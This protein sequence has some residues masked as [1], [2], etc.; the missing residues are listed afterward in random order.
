MKYL[1]KFLSG[2]YLYGTN[3]E[4]SDKDTRGVFIADKLHYLGFLNNI[5]QIEEKKTDTVYY[6]LKKFFNLCSN[7]NPNIVEFLFVPEDKLELNSK[8]WQKI[9]ENRHLFLSTKARWTFSGYAFSQLNRIKSHREWL[10]NPPK[11]KPERK[12]FGL[13]TDRKV[14]SKEQIG[15]FNQILINY[16]NK[17]KQYHNLKDELELLNEDKGMDV[18]VQQYK[19]MPSEKLVKI[20]PDFSIDFIELVQKEKKFN[21]SL[22]QYNQYLNWKKTR[23]PVRAKL[24]EKYG[25]DTKHGLHLV[26]LINEGE[27]LLLNGHIT[28]PRPD[29]EFLLSIKNGN[30]TYD[31]L[32]EYI[33]DLEQKFNKMV[34]KSKLPKKPNRKQLDKLCIELIE[35][36][37]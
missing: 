9:V 17:I 8:E 6:E 10:I 21:Q 36:N 7:C 25:F 12:D 33:G 23:N 19:E 18:I 22:K 14:V 20:V 16:L 5:E 37:I 24:E 27:E 3:D 32:M 30:F 2:S 11:K 29:A 4:N 34:E 28:F 26:R 31:K 15:A 35:Q 13:P 1:S